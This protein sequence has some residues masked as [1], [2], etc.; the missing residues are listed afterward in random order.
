MYINRLGEVDELRAILDNMWLGLLREQPNPDEVKA[1]MDSCRGISISD[2]HSGWEDAED[3]ISATQATLAS[4]KSASAMTKAAECS[5]NNVDHRI[6]YELL[7]PGDYVL[8]P[9]AQNRLAQRINLHEE[10]QL[11]IRTQLQQLNAL[12]TKESIS[13]LDLLSMA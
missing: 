8:S 5:I 12:L 9:S 6:R 2:Q 11:E 13:Q 1:L 4:Y 10:F 3:A 7:G